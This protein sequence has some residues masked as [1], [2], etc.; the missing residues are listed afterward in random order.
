MWESRENY[1][2]MQCVGD[3]RRMAMECRRCGAANGP[4]D[5]YCVSCATL[6]SDPRKGGMARGNPRKRLS[7]AMKRLARAFVQSLFMLFVSFSLV[8][9]LVALYDVVNGHRVLVGLGSVLLYLGFIVAMSSAWALNRFPEKVILSGYS[10][11][12]RVGALAPY[13]NT[14]YSPML[15]SLEANPSACVES[16]TLRLLMVGLVLLFTGMLML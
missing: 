2:W 16:R 15:K 1:M 13:Y 7:T 5:R 6:L 12:G 9:V 8:V 4:D 3:W 11:R 10:W 14:I